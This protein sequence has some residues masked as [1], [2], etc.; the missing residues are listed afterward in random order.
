MDSRRGE[1]SRFSYIDL[2]LNC[3]LLDWNL[4]LGLTSDTM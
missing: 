3:V 1:N 2:D 4:D